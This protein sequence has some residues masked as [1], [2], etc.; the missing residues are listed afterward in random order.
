MAESDWPQIR[1]DLTEFLSERRHLFFAVKDSFG[2][3]EDLG[4]GALPR[5]HFPN[6]WLRIIPLFK[7][8]RFLVYAPPRR[9]SLDDERKIIVVEP[10]DALL[11]VFPT[12]TPVGSGGGGDEFERR[13][14]SIPDE[15]LQGGYAHECAAYQIYMR[16]VPRRFR[17]ALTGIPDRQKREDALAAAHGYGAELLCFLETH[18][19]L[20]IY[21]PKPRYGSLFRGSLSIR[22]ELE[23]RINF[24]R[25]LTNNY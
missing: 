16:R 7:S 12:S 3:G 17:Q 23:D 18:L 25:G 1:L 8:S 14:L 13:F 6:T 10:K 19:E 9:L 20:L 2:I 15:A 24:L 21:E 22:D 11:S 5:R 4:L